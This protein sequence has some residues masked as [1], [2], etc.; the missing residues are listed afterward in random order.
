MP[1]AQLRLY[2]SLPTLYL[3]SMKQSPM[4]T[5]RFT[6]TRQLLVWPFTVHST[7]QCF[8][9]ISPSRGSAPMLGLLLSPVLSERRRLV[10]TGSAGI[11]QFTILLNLFL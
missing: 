10:N 8:E 1:K 3:P 6:Y 7:Y 2:L 5:D 11:S 4:I 9:T